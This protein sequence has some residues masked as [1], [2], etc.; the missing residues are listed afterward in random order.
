[1]ARAPTTSK[2]AP[3]HVV[4]GAGQIGRQLAEVLAG[5]GKAVRLVRRG[6]AGE[7]SPGIEWMRGDITEPEFA[8]AVCRGAAVVYNTAN[9]PDYAS[10]GER[11]LPLYRA[12]RDA[13]ARAG[14]RLV[15]L[16]NLYMYGRPER[17]PF[18]EDTPVRPCSA[19]GALRAA[20][21]EELLA[22]HARGD[23]Q[24]SVGR[25]SDYFGPK[26]P[27]TAVFRP[28]AFSRLLAGKA[29]YMVGGDPD[30]PHSYSYS[31]DV[32]HALSVL[33]ER[34]EAIGRVWHL[35]T[36]AQESTRQLFSRFA[37]QAGVDLRIRVVPKWA[38]RGIAIASPMAR[39]L[40]EMVY[41]WELPYLIDDRR[42]CETFG[43]A[44]TPV[45]EAV[46]ATLA[47]YLGQDRA[48]GQARAA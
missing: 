18:D 5:Q 4:V 28:D 6:P 34:E 45:D 48:G 41:Q 35:P 7:A 30:M 26:T 3:L 19:K 38:L 39:S 9:P 47:D 10:W 21:A 43:V 24:V 23:V 40:L 11:L 22:S 1:M 12:V 14:A 46:A 29:V 36:A 2:P 15:Q 33:G 31:P 16:D 20:W 32:A 44:A 37:A 42:F 17:A 13:A 25:A 8:D 27:N